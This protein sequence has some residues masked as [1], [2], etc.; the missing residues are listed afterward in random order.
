[1]PKLWLDRLERRLQIAALNQPI[2]L[3]QRHV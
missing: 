2:L 1:M 3:E